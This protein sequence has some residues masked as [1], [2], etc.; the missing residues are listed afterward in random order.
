MQ[1]LTEE[2]IREIADQLDCGF[3]S[4]IHRVSNELLFVPDFTN[5][6]YIEP[7]FFEEELKKLEDNHADYIEIEKP[8]S[9]DSFE[10]MANF[11]D[12]I[13]DNKNLKNQLT[14]ALNKKKP[15]KEFKFVI[16]NAGI[17]RQQW[18]VF[19]NEKLKQWVIDKLK[20]ASRR[21]A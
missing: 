2:Q 12:E 5:Y 16:D 6:P 21:K 11:T 3:R 18:F 19:K 20:E 9:H 8:S 1:T 15:F 10:W 13:I 14:R 4:F 17:Y 7:E